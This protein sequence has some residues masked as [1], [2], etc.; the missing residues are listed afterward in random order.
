MQCT[1]MPKRSFTTRMDEAVLQ[2]AQRVAELERRS[3]T[4]VLE[5]AVLEYGRSKGIEPIAPATSIS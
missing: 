2:V 1:F 4:S 3:V 5:V